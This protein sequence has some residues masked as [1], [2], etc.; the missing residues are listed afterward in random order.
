MVKTASPVGES[1]EVK[2]GL[3]PSRRVTVPVGV[4]IVVVAT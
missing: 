1:G 2:R 3:L 4:P